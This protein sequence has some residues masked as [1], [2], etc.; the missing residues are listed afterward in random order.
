MFYIMF[1]SAMITILDVCD[2]RLPEHMLGRS[3]NMFYNM[4][5]VIDCRLPE[6]MLGRSDNMF[7]NMLSV[8]DC[9]LPEHMLVRS[10]NMFYNVLSVIDCGLPDQVSGSLYGNL[11]TSNT[12]YGA[13]FQFGCQNLYGVHGSSE[14][15]D[16]VVRCLQ[17]GRWD[18]GSLRCEGETLLLPEHW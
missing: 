14:A 15:G 11:D 4:L 10:D 3:D 8:I 1:Y 17:D 2:C 13:S 18:F 12:T 9:R 7:Y 5:S 16:S 6:H